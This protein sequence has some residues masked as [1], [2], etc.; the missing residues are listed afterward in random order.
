MLMTF[1]KNVQMILW[2]FI[3]K[4]F[5]TIL[6]NKLENLEIKID[7]QADIKFSFNQAI[8]EK[9]YIEL[10]YI[11]YLFHNNFK[12]YNPEYFKAANEYE[13]SKIVL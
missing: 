1:Q 13:E 4:K 12:D 2:I 11:L 9:L 6:K 8:N 10:E 3:L 7:L 5:E